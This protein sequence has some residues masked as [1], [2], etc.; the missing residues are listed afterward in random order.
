MDETDFDSLIRSLA[1]P[2]RRGLLAARC[3]PLSR[4][5]RRRC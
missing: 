5:H 4:R 3:R 2:T 1:T